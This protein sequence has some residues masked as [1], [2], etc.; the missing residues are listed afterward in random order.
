MHKNIFILV[1]IFFISSCSNRTK[2][3]MN[4]I[5][6]EY[7]NIVE[8]GHKYARQLDCPTANIYID[9]PLIKPGVYSCLVTLNNKL[10]KSMCYSDNKSPNKLEAHLFNYQ[11]NLYNQ[12]I[13]VKLLNF[14]RDPKEVK[15]INDLKKLIK[16]D[17]MLCE[18]ELE[19]SVE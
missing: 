9:K 5:E 19:N 1:T 10:Y 17:K 12:R 11:G 2:S 8:K 4:L 14:I 3:S 13:T 15:S 6:N 18:K 7:T 16:L